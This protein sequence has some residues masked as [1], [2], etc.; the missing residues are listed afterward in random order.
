[1]C[2][3]KANWDKGLLVLSE[4]NKDDK[5]QQLAVQDTTADSTD[6]KIKV[7]DGWWAFAELTTEPLAKRNLKAHAV[8]LYRSIV[9]DTNGLTK[10]KIEKRLN[11]ASSGLTPSL[12]RSEPSATRAKPG[13]P[14]PR[15]IAVVE[16]NSPGGTSTLP[17]MSDGTIEGRGDARWALNN[18]VVIFYWKNPAAPGGVWVDRCTLSRDRQSYKGANQNHLEITGKVLKG[19]L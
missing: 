5:T 15:E 7:A 9:S 14:E 6:K 18:N 16:H 3:Y 17:L 1:M 4:G 8:A 12:T 2:F 11:E 19:K 13:P 10:A